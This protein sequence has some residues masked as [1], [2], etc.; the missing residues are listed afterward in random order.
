MKPVQPRVRLASATALSLHKQPVVAQKVKFL[1]SGRLSQDAREIFLY[2]I[3][4]KEWCM[5]IPSMGKYEVDD[6]PHL[7]SEPR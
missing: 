3:V 1:M 6:R 7:V 4:E 5:G 2:N